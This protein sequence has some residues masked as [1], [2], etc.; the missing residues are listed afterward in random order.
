MTR[1]GRA[2][3]SKLDAGR[4]RIADGSAI[5][6]TQRFLSGRDCYQQRAREPERLF[7]S[8]PT[9][10]RPHS[11]RHLRPAPRPGD[12]AVPPADPKALPASPSRSQQGLNPR[13]SRRTAR[14]PWRHHPLTRL[15]RRCRPRRRLTLGRLPRWC[16]PRTR[17]LLKCPLPKCRLCARRWRRR[18][19]SGGGGRAGPVPR[20]RRTHPRSTTLVRL[21][22][23]VRSMAPFRST[24]LLRSTRRLRPL[25]QCR[26][27][28]GGA[29]AADPGPRRRLP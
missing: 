9:T 25:R 28:P 19:R 6:P 18:R 10:Q 29:P 21:I 17:P 5:G 2:V 22:A 23:L 20:P 1:N 15:T 8:C 13:H 3:V 11:T 27:G 4:R 26:R 12:P 7:S 14:P 16:Q 24:V